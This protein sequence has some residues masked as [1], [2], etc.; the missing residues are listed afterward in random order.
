M[1]L[2]PKQEHAIYYL[3]DKTTKEVLYGG[4]AGGGK[5]ALGCLWL[6]EMCQKHP[7]S[8]WLMGRAKLKALKE[9]TLNTFFEL[10]SEPTPESEKLGLIRLGIT[11]QYV[12]N[13]HTNIIKWSNGSEILLKDL[14][15]YPSDPHF[16]SLGSLEICGAFID[17][18]NQIVVKAWQIVLSRCRYKLTELN[19]SPKIF[20][21]C[22]PSKNWVYKMF[23]KP[24]KSNTLSDNRRFIQALPTD[25]PHLPKSYLDSLL[26]LDKNSKERLYY[27][28][29]EYDN[30]PS[31][32]IDIDSIT[33]YFKP[34]HIKRS[35][36]MRMTIDVARKGK[37]NT[38]FRVWDGW[39]CVFRYSIDKSDLVYV[40][41]KAKE[42]QLKYGVSNSN[43]VA[44]EDGVG[45][46]VV[47]FLGCKG[48]V[49]NSS[50]IEVN[51]I[52]ENFNNLKTQC[53]YHIAKMIVK[54]EIG[55]ICTNQDIAD[56]VSEEMEQVKQKDID[57]D[58]KI[59]LVG[60]DVV[61]ANIGR[62]PDEWDSIMM[63][64]Y[65][66]LQPNVFFF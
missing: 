36:R 48:F 27:G 9:T 42:F 22:N 62:S 25:N 54:R 55:E 53:S 13:A 15:L 28:N 10:T 6:I 59:M 24:N 29:W 17:E 40:V 50:P 45:G 61:K 4:A 2:L 44:D 7:K 37:D 11:N 63:L 12:F 26:S 47:D 30:D 31:A 14:F 65:F 3:K 21:S 56:I 49:N 46:G 38:V 23:Y 51:G 43:T 20:G 18:C 32:L 57:K 8:R 41:K 33:D 66:E 5:S 64:Y 34:N 19:I 1:K 58:G 35:G 60:K 52:K 16:D 39:L